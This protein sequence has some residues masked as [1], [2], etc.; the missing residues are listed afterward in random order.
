MNFPYHFRRKIS[1]KRPSSPSSK[2]L[3]DSHRTALGKSNDLEAAWV[4]LMEAARESQVLTFDA[5]TRSGQPWA[6]DP[7]A[8]RAVAAVLRE[9]PLERRPDP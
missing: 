1:A 3:T 5:H 2:T 4:E 7:T 6:D 8:V 9:Y